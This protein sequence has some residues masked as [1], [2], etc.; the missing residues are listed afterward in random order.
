MCGN[1]ESEASMYNQEK[2][3]KH[4]LMVGKV[5]QV[6]NSHVLETSQASKGSQDN[7]GTNIT[8]GVRFGFGDMCSKH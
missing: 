4:V 8:I 7:Q 3:G 1:L 6:I 5:P 2:E